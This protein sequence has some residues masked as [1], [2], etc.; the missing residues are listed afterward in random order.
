MA[1][2]SEYAT[3][4][5]HVVVVLHRLGRATGGWASLAI[6]GN[7]ERE[8]GQ[9][10]VIFRFGELMNLACFSIAKLEREVYEGRSVIWLHLGIVKRACLCSRFAQMVHDCKGT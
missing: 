1:G 3:L 9:N 6:I 10:A 2:A 8:R 7:S 5:F 4:S